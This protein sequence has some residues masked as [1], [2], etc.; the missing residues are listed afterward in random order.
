MILRLCVIIGRALEFLGNTS[1]YFVLSMR[2]EISR[3]I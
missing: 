3:S 1:D 2:Y